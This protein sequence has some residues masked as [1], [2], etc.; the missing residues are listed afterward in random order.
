MPQQ[1]VTKKRKRRKEV[2]GMAVQKRKTVMVLTMLR[3]RKRSQNMSRRKKWMKLSLIMKE[4]M[5][6]RREAETKEKKVQVDDPRKSPGA[7]RRSLSV[8]AITTVI[9]T[10]SCFL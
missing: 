9:V 2:R 3:A 1:K 7:I 5:I 4:K 10:N 8:Q 6:E